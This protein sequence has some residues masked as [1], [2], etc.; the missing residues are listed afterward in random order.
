MVSNARMWV[1]HNRRCERAEV[2]MS[3]VCHVCVFLV[4]KEQKKII[5][6]CGC[7]VLFFFYYYF[8]WGAGNPTLLCYFVSKLFHLKQHQPKHSFT[9]THTH[10]QI[11]SKSARVWHEGN[12]IYFSL[13]IVISLPLFV[14]NKLKKKINIKF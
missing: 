6:I 2:G 5:I 1:C 10:T 7:V 9:H 12:K 4:V 13:L 11:K 3:E 8:K 14:Q